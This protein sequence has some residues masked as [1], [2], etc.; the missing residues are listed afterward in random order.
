MGE[1]VATFLSFAAEGAKFVFGPELITTFAFGLSGLD[2]FLSELTRWQKMG[3]PY[4]LFFVYM[5]HLSLTCVKH[6]NNQIAVEVIVALKLEL[7]SKNV[8]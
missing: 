5:F 6:K 2:K 3:K 8:A 7:K 1:Q 4:F